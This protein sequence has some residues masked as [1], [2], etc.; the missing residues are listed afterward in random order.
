MTLVEL[1]K[2]ITT[3]IVPHEFLI[4]VDK[5]NKFLARQYIQAIGNLAAGGINKISSIYEPFQ[6]SLALLTAPEDCINVLITDTF[7]ERAEDYSEFENT[8]VVCEQIDKTIINATADYTIKLPKLEEWQILDYAKTLCPAV[9]EADLMWL[10]QAAD[11][12]IERVINELDKVKLFNK[13][14]Q[15]QIFSSIRF[16][17]QTDLYKVDLFTIVN[18]LVDGDLMV[19]HDFLKRKNYDLLEPIVLANRALTSLKNIILVTQNPG[20]TAEACSVSPAQYRMLN[21]KYRSL[22][23]EAVKQKI[24]FLTNIDLALKSSKLEMSKEDMLNYLI[25]NLSYRITN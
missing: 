13:K 24:K 3:G 14:D 22:N 18:A 4:I 10:I 17:P 19:L 5:D 12:S 2:F 7:E 25:A 16:D 15:K 21:N 8:I 23:V 9:E 6:S 1:K 20:I 11:G